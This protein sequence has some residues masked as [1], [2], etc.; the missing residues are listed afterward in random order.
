MWALR[1]W[2]GEWEEGGVVRPKLCFHNLVSLSRGQPLLTPPLSSLTRH[3]SFTFIILHRVSVPNV[4][5]HNE[6]LAVQDN[7]A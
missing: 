6:V 7:T 5:E 4:M 1:R 2:I 3:R